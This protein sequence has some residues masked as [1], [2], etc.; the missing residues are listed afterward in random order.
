MQY[1]RIG[2]PSPHRARP[3]RRRVLRWAGLGAMSLL[4]AAKVVDI[5]V[6][7]PSVGHWRSA[8]AKERYEAAYAQ[9]LAPL[10]E[11]DA[12]RDLPTRFGSVRALTWIGEAPGPPVLLL[13][14]RSSGAPMWAENL[15]GWIGR[16]TVH[17][18]D[19]IGDAGFSTQNLPMASP[20]DQS[21]WIADAAEGLGAEQAH[22]V[23]HSFGGASAAL[24]ALHRPQLVR[25]LGLLEPVIVVRPLPAS[26]YLWS[27]LL[28]LPA[29]QSWKDEALGRIGGASAEEVRD[30]GPMSR[31]IDEA[32]TG[33]AAALPTPR[34]LTDAQWSALSMPVRLDIGEDS[35]LAGGPAAAERIR[36]LLPQAT[37]TVWPGA[38]HSLPMEEKESLGPALLDFWALHS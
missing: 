1:E 32:T 12:V 25:T 8:G 18:L 6:P 34:K 17:A 26:M 33:Y 15:P 22:V 27:A 21:V 23:G 2:S 29:P 14:G 24:L 4:A 10:P 19:P 31:M 37:V 35:Q 13:P 11:P 7:D 9:T 36:G 28:L 20:D 3:G 38:T 16:R 5:A 30:S